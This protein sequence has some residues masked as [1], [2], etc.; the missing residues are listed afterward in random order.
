VLALLPES[1]QI[2][3]IPDAKLTLVTTAPGGLRRFT[4]PGL[5]LGVFIHIVI[6]SI[7]PF[8]E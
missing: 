6:S 2:F 3:G 8:Y 7:Q 5:D 4:A 1:G